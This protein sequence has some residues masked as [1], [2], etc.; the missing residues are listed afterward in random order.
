[1]DSNVLQMQRFELPTCL[2]EVWA[3][4]SPLSEWTDRPVVQNL[5]WQLSIDRKVIKG[6]QRQLEKLINAIA[7]Y[8][9]NFLAKDEISQLTHTFSFP[10]LTRLDLTTLELFDLFTSLEQCT[11]AISFLPGLELEIKHV[12]PAWLKLVAVLVAT[13]G[14]TT[15]SVRLILPQLPQ[16]FPQ[17]A[18]NSPIG[19][20]APNRNSSQSG[21]PKVE[22]PIPALKD[23]TVL[24]LPNTDQS[25]KEVETEDIFKTAKNGNPIL[26]PIAKSIPSDQ[27]SSIAQADT[28][29]NV[30]PK[31]QTI[32]IAD[33]PT[34]RDE[35]RITNGVIAPS[36]PIPSNLPSTPQPSTQSV[37]SVSQLSDVK[38]TD[39][40]FTALQSLVERY[41]CIA[42]SPNRSRGG[43][44]MSRYEFAAGLNACLDKINEL[45]ASGLGD[46]VGKQDIASLQN[47]QE[48]FGAELAMLRGRV[49]ALEAKTAQ[50]E[51]QQFSTTTK[52]N[53]QA[54]IP[55]KP[56]ENT[57]L[58]GRVRLNFDTTFSGK[59]RLHTR[60]PNSSSAAPPKPSVGNSAKV[61]SQVSNEVSTNSRIQITA[62]K[63]TNSSDLISSLNQQFA[64][65]R[66]PK[67]SR[68]EIVLDMSVENGQIQKITLD[69]KASTLK[70]GDTLDLIK[71]SLQ[72][73]ILPKSTNGNIQITLQIQP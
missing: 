13:V 37:T 47:L 52:L 17:L 21:K 68:G 53:A 10:R 66:L 62:L 48:E 69:S 54:I 29:S 19:E 16:A 49:D 73:W 46:K 34:R 7:D 11:N 5:R 65:L 23:I 40:A 36:A 8:V 51:A 50:L 14:I 6:N 1:M 25:P 3:E 57:T 24:P 39:W 12:T 59:D 58:N 4:R 43:L 31:D 55:V 28:S 63:A 71:R 2:L 35:S 60:L 45:I 18:T 27:P 41:G 38:T 30:P 32:K 42:G 22:V 44:T 67:D 64:S 26:E 20:S 72:T 56:N 33:K 61:R 70:D 15:S 9:E